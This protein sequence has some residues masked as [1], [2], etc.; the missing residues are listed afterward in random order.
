M[1]SFLHAADLHLD[2]P[3]TG[4][5]AYEGAPVE[6]IRGATRR[7]LENLVDLALAE[8]VDAL[9][10][11]GDI[12]DGDWRDYNTGL[13][14]AGQMARLKQA[15]IPVFMVQGNH[16]AASQISRQLRL[17]DNVHLFPSRRPASIPLESAGLMVHGQS[18][19]SR[20][21][22]QNLARAYPPAE[23]GLF[24]IG[25]LHTSLDGRPGHA[26]YAPCRLDDLQRLGYD[27]WALGHVHQREVV[28]EDPW[29]VFSG[30]LQGRHARETGVKGATLVRIDNARVQA[31][32]H[33]PLDAMRWALC[34]IAVD[35]QLGRDGLEERIAA[36]LRAELDA[37]DGRLL[38]VRLRL[39][40]STCHDGAL[41]ARAE[42]FLNQCRILALECGGRGIWIEKLIIATE[43]ATRAATGAEKSDESALSPLLEALANPESLLDATSQEPTSLT[44][45][46][47]EDIADLERKLP[48][49]LANENDPL[50]L[51]FTSLS[52]QD[53]DLHQCLR[54]AHALL[55]ERLQGEPE[56]NPR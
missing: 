29:V 46:M 27:Y 54:D 40:G 13:F 38:A 31:V 21:V 47:F 53:G 32:E 36:A 6:D 2:S 25:L 30:N 22:E 3:L 42:E 10:L 14:F 45:A 12:Y 49:S 44:T 35:D 19:P 7:A 18:Y 33:Q 34:E 5:E 41:R 39:H 17:P 48:A 24:N 23:A 11:A 4:L 1:P 9:L 28:S 15:D 51:S 52:R 8:F 56:S 55:L 20:Q 26:S 16:D 37:A 50:D 43:R